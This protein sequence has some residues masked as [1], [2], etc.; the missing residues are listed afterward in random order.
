[1]PH[2]EVAAVDDILVREISS[3]RELAEKRERFNV[4]ELGVSRDI[5]P[6]APRYVVWE[7][8]CV[9]Q[10]LV[11]LL[12]TAALHR[13]IQLESHKKIAYIRTYLG[14]SSRAF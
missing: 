4:G 13:Q 1:M 12:H 5:S 6:V 8:I 11:I 7:H 9:S 10:F 14:R 2:K 3:T